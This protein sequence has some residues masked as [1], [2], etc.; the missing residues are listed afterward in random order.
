MSTMGKAVE[1][2]GVVI[3]VVGSIG[4][5]GYYLVRW[6]SSDRMASFNKCRQSVARSVLLGLEFLVAADLIHTVAVDPTFRSVGALAV[7]V[8]IR[9][10]LSIEL[11]MEIEGRWPWQKA[12]PTPA[13]GS[14]SGSGTAGHAKQRPT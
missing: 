3:I 11:E 7:I 6:R 9:T 2:V 14:R 13:E 12:P 8:A 1:S 4:A 10:F 5:F